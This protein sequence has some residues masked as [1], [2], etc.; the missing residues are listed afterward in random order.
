MEAQQATPEGTEFSVSGNR[1]VFPA[2]H[3]HGGGVAL[4]A[5]LIDT[6]IAFPDDGSDD[7]T[8]TEWTTTGETV[9]TRLGDDEAAESRVVRITQTSFGRER[10][11]EVSIVDL[12]DAEMDGLN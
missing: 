2:E 8:Q 11:V 12:A 3:E 4:T 10:T 5:G 6:I 1:V 7:E 9:T